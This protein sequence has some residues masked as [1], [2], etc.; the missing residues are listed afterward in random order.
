MSQG[1]QKN[2]VEHT[3]NIPVIHADSWLRSAL[4]QLG[5]LRTLKNILWDFNGK[6]S[7]KW[8]L[9]ICRVERYMGGRSTYLHIKNSQATA[10]LHKD[11][12]ATA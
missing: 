8:F 2:K 5:H 11:D 7:Q 10:S 1:R 6:I 4:L 3:N 12:N 9:G